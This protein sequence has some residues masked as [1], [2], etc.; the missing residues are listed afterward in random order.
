MGKVHRTAHAPVINF[1]AAV[2]VFMHEYTKTEI[3]SVI[4]KTVDGVEKQGLIVEE[5][6]VACG[7]CQSFF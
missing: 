5:F 1:P 2:R 7:V 3:T 6:C 4:A